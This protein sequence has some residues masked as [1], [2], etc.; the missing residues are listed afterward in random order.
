MDVPT[1]PNN[2]TTNKNNLIQNQENQNKPIQNLPSQEIIGNVQNTKNNESI[3]K[4]EE[5][6]NN[7]E[8]EEIRV[9]QK[10]Q[11]ETNKKKSIQ[12]EKSEI[13]KKEFDSILEEMKKIFITNKQNIE[14]FFEKINKTI[15]SCLSQPCIMFLKDIINAIFIFLCKYFTFIKDNFKEIPLNI[16]KKI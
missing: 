1:N 15:T 10:E 8:S 16:M 14:T 11:E 5:E 3:N 12:Q 4:K 7:E 9:H 2:I 13:I 6:K